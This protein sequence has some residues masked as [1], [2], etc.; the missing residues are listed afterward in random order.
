MRC[1]CLSDN[2]TERK[3]IVSQASVFRGDRRSMVLFVDPRSVSG[4]FPSSRSILF[5]PRSAG[6][7][8]AKN[9]DLVLELGHGR[10]GLGLEGWSDSVA[11]A[12]ITDSEIYN[13]NDPYWF[14][15]ARQVISALVRIA[16]MLR[17]LELLPGKWTR[18]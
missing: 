3:Q 7:R 10:N 12:C 9:L 1:G 14:L 5:A 4:I 16:G 13:V 17:V 2:A 18:V 15:T 11:K 8:G 6:F